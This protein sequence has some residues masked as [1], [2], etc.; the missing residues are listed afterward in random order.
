LVAPE[1]GGWLR[2]RDNGP[3]NFPPIHNWPGISGGYVGPGP[4]KSTELS[5]LDL[6]PRRNCAWKTEQLAGVAELPELQVVWK[7]TSENHRQ[8]TATKLTRFSVFH[9]GTSTWLTFYPPRC[10]VLQ[11]ELFSN[12]S[13]AR[14]NRIRCRLNTLHLC[15]LK[16][17]LYIIFDG[18]YLLN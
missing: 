16:H 2:S 11:A 9:P 3:R 1:A 10:Q 14:F 4:G 5:R 17:I 7:I 8:S 18:W 13:N 15:H 6:P 12:F